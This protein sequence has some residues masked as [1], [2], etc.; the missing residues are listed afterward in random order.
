MRLVSSRNS[1]WYCRV[2]SFFFSNMCRFHRVKQ[3]VLKSELHTL[4]TLFKRFESEKQNSVICYESE[5]TIEREKA[6][7]LKV[8]FISYRICIIF[9]QHF[10][11]SVQVFWK[12]QILLTMRRECDLHVLDW[13]NVLEIMT[14]QSLHVEIWLE[15]T[16]FWVEESVIRNFDRIENWRKKR[17]HY[18]RNWGTM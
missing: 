17:K 3:T 15:K 10:C 16:V 1:D 12:G 7:D 2:P 11:L 13:S 5:G 4:I 14:K 6:K 8:C 18:T 9:I